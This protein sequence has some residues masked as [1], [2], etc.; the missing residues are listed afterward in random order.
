MYRVVHSMKGHSTNGQHY[1]TNGH[2]LPPGDP[3]VAAARGDSAVIAADSGG[4]GRKITVRIRG[5]QSMAASDSV[6]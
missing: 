2:L 3:A 5:W 6:E 1:S 4:D